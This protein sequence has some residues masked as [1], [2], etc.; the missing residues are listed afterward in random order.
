M[1]LP[2]FMV[3]WYFIEVPV[4]KTVVVLKTSSGLSALRSWVSTS[5]NP[6]VHEC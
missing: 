2:K 3:D 5:L 6:Q 4:A 1:S